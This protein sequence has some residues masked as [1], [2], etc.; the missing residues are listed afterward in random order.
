[1]K[2]N[3]LTV[4]EKK[5]AKYA[6]EKIIGKE[7]EAATTRVQYM[8]MAAM[9]NCGW[10]KNDIMQVAVELNEVTEK[11][12]DYRKDGCAD[13][14]LMRDLKSAGIALRPIC[15]TSDEI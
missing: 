1:M 7:I 14:A 13:Y 3:V 8:W 6:A 9:L 4:K 10:N 11:Y 2:A 5:A 12:G 15:D